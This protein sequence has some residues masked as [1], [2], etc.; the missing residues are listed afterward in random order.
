MKRWMM[1][2]LAVAFLAAAAA[3]AEARG[4]SYGRG[5]FSRGGFSRHGSHYRG[6]H[7]RGSYYRG[8]SRHHSSF[9]V[10]LGC[11]P[12]LSYWNR[13]LYVGVGSS[14]WYSSYAYPYYRTSYAYYPSY[15]YTYPT[16]VTSYPATS[17]TYTTTY[18]SYPTPP[19]PPQ[20]QMV[21]GWYHTSYGFWCQCHGYQRTALNNHS[22]QYDTTK[23]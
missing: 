11:W 9:R 20:P 7:Y 6:S 2:G 22:Y 16:A 12:S 1:I 17:A 3:S 8:G 14:P 19:P 5:S 18:S 21:Q 13:G 4:G 10:S 15:T 23:D